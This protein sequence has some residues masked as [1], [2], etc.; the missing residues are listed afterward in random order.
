MWVKVSKMGYCLWSFLLPEFE[1]RCL[2][3]QIG[4]YWLVHFS[5]LNSLITSTT[6]DPSSL[7]GFPWSSCVSS[8][9]IIFIKPVFNHR[10]L[11]HTLEQ[12]KKMVHEAYSQPHHVQL[13]AQT[14]RVQPLQICQW[15]VQMQADAVLPAYP[16]PHTVEEVTIIKD[17]KKIEDT[18]WRQ[19]HRNTRIITPWTSPIHGWP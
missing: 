2:F 6:K 16:Y 5:C 8:S 1:W 13:T 15:R 14:R 12:K 11:F 17:H 4:T 9:H 19:T 18:E 3:I 7:L 10:L